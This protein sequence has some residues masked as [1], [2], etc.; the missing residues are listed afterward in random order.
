MTYLAISIQNFKCLTK[1]VSENGLYDGLKSYRNRISSNK[2]RPK[3]YI[4]RTLKHENIT[5]VYFEIYI[6]THCKKKKKTEILKYK[7][8]LVFPTGVF[9]MMTTD[10]IYTENCIHNIKRKFR[11]SP[12]MV[13]VFLNI[14]IKRFNMFFLNHVHTNPGK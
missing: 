2:R 1:A 5:H 14:Q 6:Y 7:N 13:F 3:N 12:L 11:N 8:E 9:I 10:S 4:W